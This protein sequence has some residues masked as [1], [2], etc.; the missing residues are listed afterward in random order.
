MQL[1]DDTTSKSF[2]VNYTKEGFWWGSCLANVNADCDFDEV[3]VEITTD[4]D[5]GGGSYWRWFWWSSC[6][7]EVH[8]YCDYVEVHVLIDV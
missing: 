1:R 7:G 4:C 6:S 8:D 3:Y 2:K 5:Y